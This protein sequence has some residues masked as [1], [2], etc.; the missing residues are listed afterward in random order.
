MREY[1]TR[2]LS[3][4]VADVDGFIRRR[5]I[6][7]LHQIAV[8]SSAMNFTEFLDIFPL[9]G[10]LLCAFLWKILSL[11]SFRYNLLFVFL[12]LERN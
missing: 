11:D 6:Q 9:C 5:I 3:R 12:K 10:T 8:Q 2:V 4:K 7:L 1:G